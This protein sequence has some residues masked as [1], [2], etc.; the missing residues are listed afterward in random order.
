MRAYA[1]A[2]VPIGRFIQLDPDCICS[3]GGCFPT[4]L[5]NLSSRPVLRGVA[6]EA[7]FK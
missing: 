1:K 7:C 6:R 2:L 5:M 4:A 3:C